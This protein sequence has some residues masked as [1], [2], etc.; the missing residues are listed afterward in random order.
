MYNNPEDPSRFPFAT[1]TA[2]QLTIENIRRGVPYILHQRNATYYLFHKA[3]LPEKDG[4]IECVSLCLPICVGME[5]LWGCLGSDV[6]L[7]SL[8]PLGTPIHH[9][10][11]SKTRPTNQG[12]GS[13][14]ACSTGGFEGVWV[15]SHLELLLDGNSQ[16]FSKLHWSEEL[17][18]GHFSVERVKL[19]G[20]RAKA[21][22][23]APKR[24]GRWAGNLMW[25][26]VEWE[27]L[28]GFLGDVPR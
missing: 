27:V 11:F 26:L 1:E 13:S 4:P 8:P 19:A 25:W 7:A 3:G 6:I 17:G 21:S 12:E 24:E 23:H 5:G 18:T 9:V 16:K 20:P 28:L 2:R 22:Q 15:I 10:F 14:P